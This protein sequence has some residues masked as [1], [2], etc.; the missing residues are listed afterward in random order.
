MP[1]PKSWP[2][3]FRSIVIPLFCSQPVTYILILIHLS[4]SALPTVCGQSIQFPTNF[5]YFTSRIFARTRSGSLRRAVSCQ[6]FLNSLGFAYAFHCRLCILTVCGS[7][8]HYIICLT[9]I[10]F[11]K[12]ERGN[13][14]A[15]ARE[16]HKKL[17]TQIILVFFLPVDFFEC[18]RC[19][20]E[21]SFALE[22]WNF[23]NCSLWREWEWESMSEQRLNAVDWC[24]VCSVCMLYMA[25]YRVVALSTT[26]CLFAFSI[27]FFHTLWLCFPFT[28]CLMK[29]PDRCI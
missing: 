16:H 26:V 8:H 11:Q 24:V 18:F 29:N 7:A 2:M 14:T 19:V 6:F 15:R 23:K 13:G 3:N 28:S 21:C 20:C 12:H 25:V 22:K 1:L 10:C 17:F 5:N 27:L 9:I 4:C